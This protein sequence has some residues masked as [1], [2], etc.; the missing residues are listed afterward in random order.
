VPQVTVFKC[1]PVRAPTAE[2]LEVFVQAA[3]RS[4][5]KSV[6]SWVEVSVGCRLSVLA[7]LVAQ[8]QGRD[9]GRVNPVDL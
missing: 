2:A 9:L 3:V 7:F 6:S 4:R 8:R 1:V 5:I